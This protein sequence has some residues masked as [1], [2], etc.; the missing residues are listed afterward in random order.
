MSE[1]L[2]G[3]LVIL[4]HDEGSPATS[5]RG[6]FVSDQ[7]RWALAWLQEHAVLSGLDPDVTLCLEFV[8]GPR[9]R[10]VVDYGEREE[11]V[12]LAARRIS[13]G[14]ELDRTALTALAARH[15]LPVVSTRVVPSLDALL[16]EAEDAVGIEGWV[17]RHPE[18]GA[19]IKVKVPEYHRLHKLLI[20]LTPATVRDALIAEGSVDAL[21]EQ[22]PEE[23]W[24]EIRATAAAIEARVE[25]RHAALVRANEAIRAASDG[26]RKHHAALIGERERA[27]AGH[28]FALLD[29]QDIR[30]ALRRVVSLEGL[31]LGRRGAPDPEGPR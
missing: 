17:I 5:T 3:S 22:L 10:V 15:R 16:A 19:R 12:L 30:P 21:C 28:H 1:K 11:V 4:W 27:D 7:A 23:Y 20:R 18:S 25:A 31:S 26:T 14:R 8:S 29:E 2:D 9:N 24:D 6:S 13:D